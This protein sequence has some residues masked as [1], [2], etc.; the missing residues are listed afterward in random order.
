MVNG[1]T[2]ENKIHI[3]CSVFQT[4]FYLV[5]L[6]IN[7]ND[8]CSSSLKLFRSFSLFNTSSAYETKFFIFFLQKSIK[9]LVSPE[10]LKEKMYQK[11]NKYY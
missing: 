10:I 3:L 2:I 8:K 4:D 5:L 1:T 9:N 6:I 11:M 7:E